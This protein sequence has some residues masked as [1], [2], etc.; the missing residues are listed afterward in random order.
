MT[1]GMGTDFCNMGCRAA[2]M[3]WKRCTCAFKSVDGFYHQALGM[4]VHITQ[5]EMTHGFCGTCED[6]A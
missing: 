4:M 5:D 2:S 6:I 3:G 1:V